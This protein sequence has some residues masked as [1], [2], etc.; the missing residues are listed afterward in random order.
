MHLSK[1]IELVREKWVWSAERYPG[2][3]DEA[4]QG[5]LDRDP[6]SRFQRKHVLMHMM[7]QV[8]GLS[9]A[10]QDCDHDPHNGYRPR[11]LNRRDEIAKLLIDVLQF[12]A[13]EGYTEADLVSEMKKALM[14][15]NQPAAY[16]NDHVE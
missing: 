9:A 12:A 2:L 6:R 5:R 3:P 13:I 8:G 11:E 10:E 7:K 4:R 15:G 16:V 14:E 1:L